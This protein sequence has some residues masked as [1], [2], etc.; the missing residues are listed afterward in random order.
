MRIEGNQFAQEQEV[1]RIL[2]TAE[3]TENP[4]DILNLDRTFWYDFKINVK[5]LKKK[6]RQSSLLIHP[7]ILYS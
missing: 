5:A 6:Y 4:I 1:E 2:S 3:D 7:G